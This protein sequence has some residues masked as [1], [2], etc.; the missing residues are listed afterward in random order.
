MMTGLGLM[1]LF[2]GLLMLPFL[3]FLIGMPAWLV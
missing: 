1:G 3:L 2:G